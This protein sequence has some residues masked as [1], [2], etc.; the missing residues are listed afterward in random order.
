MSSAGRLLDQIHLFDPQTHQPS[1]SV[2]VFARGIFTL[3]VSTADSLDEFPVSHTDLERHRHRPF[4]K[5]FWDTPEKPLC[6][7]GLLYTVDL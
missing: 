3:V 6:I 1:H 7:N 2:L 5:Q 4:I